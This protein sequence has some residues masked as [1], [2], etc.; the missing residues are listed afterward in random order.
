M[1]G[2]R[3]GRR[4]HQLLIL[5]LFA[6]IAAVVLQGT[7]VP[8]THAGVGP[9]FYNQDHDRVLLAT[10]YG[11]ATVPALQPLPVL[12][13]VAAVSL[14]LLTPATL[15]PRRAAASRAPPRS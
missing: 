6:A 1:S 10:L 14:A 8:H 2:P 15:T 4:A 3:P 7:G 11:A 13:V 5:L 12:V 9:G